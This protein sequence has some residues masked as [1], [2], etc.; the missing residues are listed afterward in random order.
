MFGTGQGN[1]GR[2]WGPLGEVQVMCGDAWGGPGRVKGLSRRSGTGQGT[3]G[4][5]VTGRGTLGEVLDGSWEPRWRTG[6]GRGT[7]EEDRD[8]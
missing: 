4:V 3:L 6:T 7:L 8:R 5:V 2:V 1:P